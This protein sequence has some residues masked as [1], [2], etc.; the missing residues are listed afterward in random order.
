MDILLTQ[1][2]QFIL[3]LSLLIVLHEMG[4]FFPARWFKVRVEKFYLFF[5]PWFSLW[6][7]KVGDTEYGVGWLPLGGYVK[8][9]GMIDESMDR[10]QMAKAPQ[11]WEFRSKPAWQ[12][13]IVMIGGVVVNLLL[14][15]VIYSMVMFVWG[16][17][18]LPLS[19]MEY[20]VHPSDQ[21]KAYGFEEGDVILG[22]AG[23]DSGTMEGLMRAI[24]L[25]DC[26]EVMVRRNGQ[27]MTISLPDSVDQSILRSER[28]ALFLPRRPFVV[29]T[30]LPEGGAAQSSLRLND[31]IVAIGEVPTP[32]F[33]D[34]QKEV[35]EHKGEEVVLGVQRAGGYMLIPVQVSAEG[36]IGAGAQPLETRKETFGFFASFPAGIEHGISVLTGQARSMKLLGTKEGAKQVGGFWRILQLFGDWGD[37]QTFWNVTAFL[38]IVLALMNILPIPALDG[39]HV[40]FLLYEMVAGKPAP[41]KVMEVA[42]LIGMILVLGLLLLANGNDIFK[43]ISGAL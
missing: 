3:C 39:G 41:E 32:F 12:R 17:E 27:Q 7:K 22:G 14:G 24:L 11:P 6:K 38:S 4:H 43:G 10:D 23:T 13:L 28:T 40:M 16:R 9:S 36:L 19:S 18:T 20:G 8:L 31:R 5:D 2:P 42:Q 37:W 25:G 21:M 1:V 35:K 30:I 15:L 26:R 33:G 34:F 29:D